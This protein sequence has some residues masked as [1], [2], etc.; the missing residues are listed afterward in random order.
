[1]HESTTSEKA[2]PFMTQQVHLRFQRD[3]IDYQMLLDL[4]KD[5][6]R[7]R[8]KI[9]DLVRKGILIRV[10]KGLYL[11]GDD[12]RRHPYSKELLANLMYGP[13]Y[14]SLQYALHYYGII[15]ERVETV[16]SVTIGRSKRYTTPLGLFTYRQIPIAAFSRGMTRKTLEG[17]RA[18]LLATPEKALCDTIIDDQGVSLRSFKSLRRYLFEDLRLEPEVL[19]GLQAEQIGEIARHYGS[20]KLR[21]LHRFLSTAPLTLEKNNE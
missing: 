10:K 16:T 14:V 20:A 9:S 11:L 5:Y 13:S 6:V 18:F 12:Y 4:F 15:P 3:E 19:T 2:P 8:D 7:P 1:M 21:L 17:D